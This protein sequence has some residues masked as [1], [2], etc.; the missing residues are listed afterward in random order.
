MR[1]ATV[2]ATQPTLAAVLA[3]RPR[4]GALRRCRRVLPLSAK[5]QIPFWPVPM[6]MQTYVVLVL[7][8]AY[9][10]RLGVATVLFYLVQGA[11]RPARIG[12][13]AGRGIGLA[14]MIG[15]TGVI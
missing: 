12:R 6:T 2:S 5:V 10:T 1:A 14:Y 13:Y 11:V 15:P 3:V 9:G 8:M 4:C 7:G